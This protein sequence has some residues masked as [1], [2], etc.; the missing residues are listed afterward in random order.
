MEKSRLPIRKDLRVAVV[1]APCNGFGDV[2]FA[3][4][5][6]R[7]LKYGLV[8]GSPLC[9]NVHI[10]TTSPDMFQKVGVSDMPII[11]LNGKKNQ[12]RRLSGYDRP[13]NCP[14]FDLI[15]IAP[16]MMD[17]NPS[18]ADVH[19]LFEEATPFNTIFLS[20]YQDSLSKRFDFHTGIGKGYC[21]LLFDGEK[22]SP[23]L[24]ILGKNAY[25]LAY[26]AGDVGIKYCLSN[27]CKMVVT[28]WAK[29]F[30]KLQLVVPAWGAKQLAASKAFR[31]YCKKY[32]NNIL[33]YTPGEKHELVMGDGPRELIIRGDI[34]PV[35][36][37]DMLSLMKYSIKDVLVT[38]D[39]S[40]TDVLDCCS[41]KNI[42]YQTVP[43]K[44][45]FAKALAAEI[46]QKW[47]SV[48]K[49]S[50]GSLS[51]IKWN[52]PGTNIKSRY[53]FRKISKGG[54]NAIFRAA[55]AA[56]TEGSYVQQYLEKLGESTSKKP[57][58]LLAQ[59]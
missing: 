44:R 5:F 22:A 38:G 13:E 17:H 11:S 55:T 59:K 58:L 51:A 43:W 35:P 32:Y 45:D 56:K 40:V 3:T 2:I 26:L 41:E 15:F 12:C 57:L 19:A 6:A 21:G 28:K 1:C 47:L 49:T 4:K 30:T 46:P 10:V 16:L 33:V 34:L 23:R 52:S 39:Q 37:P 9:D 18:Y 7:Y 36:R 50:C 53:D 29:T 31:D 8:K 20:E 48:S 42:W 27:F 14:H 24:P 54:L 25:A